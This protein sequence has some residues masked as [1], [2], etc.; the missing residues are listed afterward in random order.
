MRL[1]YLMIPLVTICVAVVGGML[2][3]TGLGEWY[4][5]IQKPGFTPPGSIIGTVWTVI[6]F[7]S[8]ISAII[9]WNLHAPYG[10][11][12]RDGRFRAVI[13]IFLLNAFLNVFW[14]YLFFNQHQKYAAF[15]EAVAL[16]ITVVALIVLMWRVTK[17]GSILLLPYA[18]W[19]AFAS[20]LTWTIWSLNR[21]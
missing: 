12:V 5:S 10:G 18:C 16:D 8:T 17:W 21:T 11:L 13:L 14:S 2:T 9:F 6:F 1:N 4:A 15:W 3:S 7:L 19:V 20:Y